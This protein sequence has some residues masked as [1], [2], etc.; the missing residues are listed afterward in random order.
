[1]WLKYIGVSGPNGEQ[2]NEVREYTD[3]QAKSFLNLWP[4][5]F[6]KVNDDEIPKKSAL[7]DKKT[8]PATTKNK[9]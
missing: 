7:E 3:Q 9:K 6:V 8:K 4:D 5:H 2:K 1:M